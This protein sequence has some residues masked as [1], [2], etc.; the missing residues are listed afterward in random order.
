MLPQEPW[1]SRASELRAEV[2]IPPKDPNAGSVCQNAQAALE[3]LLTA[4]KLRKQAEADQQRL[5]R[6]RLK[7]ERL[8]DAPLSEETLSDRGTQITHDTSTFWQRH[9]FGRSSRR[10]APPPP[11]TTLRPRGKVCIELFRR[12]PAHVD[13]SVRAVLNETQTSTH[14]LQTEIPNDFLTQASFDWSDPYTVAYNSGLAASCREEKWAHQRQMA[15]LETEETHKITY[16]FDDEDDED[17]GLLKESEHFGFSVA[18]G[19]ASL[20]GHILALYD[21]GATAKELERPKNVLPLYFYIFYITRNLKF[22]NFTC[23]KF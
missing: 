5:N 22:H 16:G 2:R 23:N 11:Q 15:Q 18:G 10:T 8:C 4:R 12:S 9:S 20:A 1:R 13:D 21:G 17:D 14:R 7:W 19:G 3:T 6:Q